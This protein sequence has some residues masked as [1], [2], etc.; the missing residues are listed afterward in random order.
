MGATMRE[1]QVAQRSPEWYAARTG[2]FTASEF[3][4]IITPTGKKSTQVEGLTNRILAEIMLGRS[5]K[6]FNGNFATQRGEELE[7]QAVECYEL[8]WDCL[9][10]PAGFCLSDCGHYGCSPDGFVG[11]DGLIEIKCVFDESHVANMLSDAPY[12]AYYPQLQGQ[13]LVTGRQWVDWVSYHP[14][15]PPVIMRVER[16]MPYIGALMDYI[17]EAVKLLESK[18]TKLK[19]MGYL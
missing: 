8:A 2:V 4:K 15:L 10:A 19:E 9:V 12:R 7:P 5:H 14:D 11:D 16:D 13:L 6:Q 1:L 18:K 17:A 3:D